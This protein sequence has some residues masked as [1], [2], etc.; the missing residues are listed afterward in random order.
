[1]Q[2]Y[3]EGEAPAEP[4]QRELR[5]PKHIRLVTLYPPRSLICQLSENFFVLGEP[6]GVVLR[7]DHFTVDDHIEYTAAPFDHFY[8]SISR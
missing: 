2:S 6:S 7:I 5:P 4:A 8:F 1:M 3:R